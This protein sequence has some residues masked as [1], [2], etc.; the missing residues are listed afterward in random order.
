MNKLSI[1]GL[2][3]VLAAGFAS[4]DNYEEPNPPAQSNPQ[5]PLLESSQVTLDNTLTSGV[6]SLQD[7]SQNGQSLEVATIT[8]P[9]YA[10]DYTYAAEAQMSVDGFNKAFDVPASVAPSAEDSTKYV[11]SI[12]PDDLQGVYFDN[13]SKGPKDKAIQLR[14]ALY[15]VST[16]ANVQKAQIGGENHFYGPY[17]LTI[18]PFPSILVHEDNYYLVGTACDWDVAKAIKLTPS[19]PE[20]GSVYDNPVF[21]AMFNVTEGGWWWKIIPESTYVT[22]N[23]VDGP[24]TQFGVVENGDESLSGVLTATDPQAGCL[25]VTGPYMLTINMEEM[26]YEFDLTI[27]QL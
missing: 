5:L 18:K 1:Y 14:Y 19:Y 9:D 15:T 20:G 26:T 8:A 21:S 24:N 3:V 7:L 23:W 22:G 11:V 27:E 10:P 13:V 12:N 6:Y 4:C 2:S 16:G 17:D 25:Q